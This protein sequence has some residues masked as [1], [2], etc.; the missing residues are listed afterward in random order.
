[1]PGFPISSQALRIDRGN[2]QN[3]NCALAPWANRLS[4]GNDALTT[5]RLRKVLVANRGEIAV[6]IIRACREAGIASVAV[7]SE[8]DRDYPHVGL[9]DEAYPLEG[10]SAGETYLSVEKLLDIARRSSAD[11]I[12]PG[13]GFLAENTDFVEACD[14][15]ELI[16]I[17]PPA[18]A[19]RQ[20]GSKI[21]ARQTMQ[22]AGVPVVPGTFEPLHGPEAAAEVANELGFPVALKAVAGGGGKGM[23]VLGNANE[24]EAAFR[25]AA[26][27]AQAAFGDESLYLEKLIE[28]PR[29]VEV[30]FLADA[31]GAVVHLGERE[32]SVQRRHQKL[33]EETP[34]PAVGPELRARMGQVA[35]Q[36]ARAVGYVNAGTVEFLLDEDGSFYFLEVNAR[37][38]VEHPVTEQVTGVDLVHW[39]FR[40]AS[41][42]PL[43]LRQEDVSWRGHAI[44]CRVYAEDPDNNFYPANGWITGLREPTGPGVRVDSGVRSGLEVSLH[45]DPMLAKL[46]VWAENR[47]AALERLRCAL[48]E[49]LL[50]GLKTDLPVHR[51]VVSHPDFI[52]GRFDVGFLER[53]WKSGAWIDDEIRGLAALAASLAVDERVQKGRVIP[54][55]SSDGSDWRM[56]ARPSWHR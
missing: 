55:P 10:V 25:S 8:P 16:F 15:A 27:E 1:V 29:H 56:V 19:M 34:S 47:P 13:Y 42:E 49:Y 2:A 31:H 7:Y 11:S 36:A 39:Q 44:E 51:F 54:A 48:H 23:R 5:R 24:M 6:R 20:V 52:A 50:L 30:Q 45:Y 37:L 3:A 28:R 9:A 53:E 22:A 4:E 38:Q 12:H 21:A 41:G 26:S 17:G 18:S 32:C 46:I 40:L 35:V 43:T 33:I 14:A